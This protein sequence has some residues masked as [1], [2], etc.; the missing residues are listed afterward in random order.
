MCHLARL[1]ACVLAATFSFHA[2]GCESAS[3]AVSTSAHATNPS[4]VKRSAA[5]V[6]Q[7]LIIKFKSVACSAQGIARFAKTAGVKLQWLRQMSGDACVL[8]QSAATPDALMNAQEGLKKH[9][10]VEWLEIDAVMQRH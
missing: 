9:P 2:V 5:Q 4:A 7:Q 3:A 1:A 8:I 6:S 10:E